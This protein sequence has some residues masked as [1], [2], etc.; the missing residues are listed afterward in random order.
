MA[1]FNCI[2]E[3][4]EMKRCSTVCVCAAVVVMVLSGCATNRPI[5]FLYQS[6]NLPQA[7]G[8]DGMA[9][10]PKVGISQCKSFLG[11]IVDG[12][13]SIAT[14]MKNGNITKVYYVDWHVENILGL[15][16]TYQCVVYGE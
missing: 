15:V 10:S 1:V 5:G 11:M 12:D 6:V 4:G 8:V 3:V 13:A 2:K 7:I 16:G 9:A 14:A